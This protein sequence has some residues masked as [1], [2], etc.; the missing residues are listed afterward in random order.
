VCVCDSLAYVST[1]PLAI[2]DVS[3]PTQPAI[4]GSIP[5]GS[6]SV[7]VKDTLAF[8]A[9]GDVFL[10][11]VAEPQM[12]VL[13]DSF[14]ANFYISAIIVVDT[15]AYLG[16]DDGVRVASVA[17]PL[18]PRVLALAPAPNVVWRLA[19]AEPYIYAVCTDAG[20]A[21]YET[22][23]TGVAEQVDT[24]DRGSE[25]RLRPNPA[26]TT[27][28]LIPGRPGRPRAVTVFDVNGRVT[29]RAG[30]RMLPD[31]S[32]I[33]ELAQLPAGVFCVEVLSTAGREVLK[34][35]KH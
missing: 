34:L 19:Y 15:F 8:V 2:V 12:P 6:W 9:G 30:V 31:G 11:D 29:P 1:Y 18:N 10:Y 23:L 3:S 14:G 5:R 16:C 22:T 33:L 24:A 4:I 21:L 28:T 7:F 25:P 26:R 13:V 17:D 27:A 32:A 35:V 20:I